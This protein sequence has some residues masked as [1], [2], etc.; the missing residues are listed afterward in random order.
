M[1]E[2][3]VLT[4]GLARVWAICPEDPYLVPVRQVN[5]NEVRLIKGISRADHLP[6]GVRHASCIAALLTTQYLED[7]DRLHDADPTR[8]VS[9]RS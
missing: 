9:E 3:F 2:D 8:R 4:E 5:A 1:D 7:A 6:E